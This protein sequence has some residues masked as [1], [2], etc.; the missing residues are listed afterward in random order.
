[1]VEFPAMM[2]R[3]SYCNFCF[4]CVKACPKDNWLLRLRTFGEDLWASTHRSMGEAYLAFVL[5]GV[6][7]V[8]TAQMLPLWGPFIAALAR[9]IPAPIRV[10]M[11]PVTYLTLSETVVFFSVSLIAVPLLGLAAAW[12][13]NRLA[14]PS[15]D[16]TKH[17]WVR[18]AYMFVPVGLAMHL[19]HNFSHILLEGKSIVAALQSALNRFSPWSLGEPAWKISP[20]VSS[21]VV[22]F[23]QMFFVLG[24]LI[25]AIIAGY[26]LAWNFLGKDRTCAKVLIPF[27]IVALSLTLLN[28]YLL[29]QP[30]GARYGM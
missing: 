23:L 11:K 24:G 9:A 1:M 22:S 7:T 13:A 18:F 19:A 20:L 10:T 6:T 15:A 28:L 29:D 21:D 2:D 30:M 12:V 3:N 27:I 14:D 5:V 26:R 25:L 16:G 8:V 4:E 17:I